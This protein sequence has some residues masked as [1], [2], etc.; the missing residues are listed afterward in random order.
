MI[1][2]NKANLA[3][4]IEHHQRDVLGVSIRTTMAAL[5][6]AILTIASFYLIGAAM[7]I[8]QSG[9]MSPF[10]AATN[11]FFAALGSVGV[12]LVEYLPERWAKRLDG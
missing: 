7:W 11:A 1:T 4:A 12:Q 5:T 2:R 8:A 9:S 6:L 10:R 3:K